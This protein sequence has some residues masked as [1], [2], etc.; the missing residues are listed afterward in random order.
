MI[1]FTAARA[2]GRAG[3]SWASGAIQQ[4]YPCVIRVREVVKSLI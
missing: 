4:R 1:D 2:R 3:P